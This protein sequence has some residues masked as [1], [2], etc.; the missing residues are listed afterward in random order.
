M[1]LYDILGV[2]KDATA[3][4][5]KKARQALAK[6]YHPDRQ[7]GDS[8]KMQAV[9]KAYDVLSDPTARKHYDETGGI[10]GV[11]PLDTAAKDT[12]RQ[13]VKQI[14]MSGNLKDEN[15]LLAT[16]RANIAETRAKIHEQRL[17]LPRTLALTERR[18][19]KITSKGS[20]TFIQDVLRNAIDGMTEQIKSLDKGLLILD[21]AVEILDEYGEVTIEYNTY[22]AQQGGGNPYAQQGPQSG[23]Y[24]NLFGGWK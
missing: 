16:L 15:N 1:S 22:Y 23:T 12:I 10:A 20:E 14:L 5:L 8:E 18:L 4:Q 7:G 24:R 6:K 21:R 2:A 3:E 11:Q 13:G 9:N 17:I 19:D